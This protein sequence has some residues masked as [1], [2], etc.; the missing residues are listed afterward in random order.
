[1]DKT[2]S[3]IIA[4]L[5]AGVAFL[6][7]FFVR[8]PKINKLKKQLK[9]LQNEIEK[10][11]NLRK[12]QNEEFKRLLLKYKALKIYQIKEKANSKEKI[13]SVLIM[14]YGLEDYLKLL[15]K[16]AEKN[17][18]DKDDIKF[19]KAYD[20]VIEGKALS[21]TDKVV[22]SS[23]IKSKHSADIEQMKE[24]NSDAEIIKLREYSV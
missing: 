8:Q 21:D 4:F 1:M 14:Q 20:N 3:A 5:A 15:F 22:I 13:T 10:L 11:E 6:I 9:T 16:R 18:L 24:S 7:G 17:K 2:L 19:L 23:Y 12:D